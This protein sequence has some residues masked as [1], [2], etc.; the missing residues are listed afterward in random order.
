VP[1]RAGR[2]VPDDHLAGDGAAGDPRAVGRKRQA[3]R[4]RAQAPE[5]PPPRAREVEDRHL[6]VDGDRGQPAAVGGER[7][8]ERLERGVD[9]RGAGLGVDEVEQAAA[10]HRG[11]GAVG[12]E[13]GEPR[14]AR[15]RDPPQL[16]IDRQAAEQRARHQVVSR[17]EGRAQPG[18]RLELAPVR[19]RHPRGLALRVGAAPLGDGLLARERRRDRQRGDGDDG[20][21]GDPGDRE[22]PAAVAVRQRP[23]L[24]RGD[25]AARAGG[26]REAPR[27][28]HRL[29]QALVAPGLV[30][31]G[32]P[33]LPERGGLL[34]V[35][36]EAQLLAALVEP[37]GEAAPRADQGLVRELQ[38]RLGSVAAAR[39]EQPGGGE[40]LDDERRVAGEVGEQRPQRDAA[41]GALRGDQAEEQRARR[42]L[43]RRGEAG[44]HLV[45]VGGERAGDAADLLVRAPREPAAHP[46]APLPEQA[47]R[48]LQ[49]RQRRRL[50][51]DGGEDV[52]DEL[53]LVE[54]IA[55]LGERAQDDLAQHLLAG[56]AEHEHARERL[57]ELGHL[58]EPAE[59]VVARREDDAHRLPGIVGGA[60]QGAKEATPILGAGGERDQLLELVD[61]QHEPHAALARPAPQDLAEERRALAQRG[62]QR[63][64]VAGLVLV[65][66]RLG[67]GGG[68]QGPPRQARLA[69]DH[70]LGEPGERVG[71][72][73]RAEE[74]PV[75]LL[76]Q[77][78]QEPRAHERALAGARRA[79]HGKERLR[80]HPLRGVRELGVAAEEEPRLR[81]VEGE[82]AAERAHVVA[83]RGARRDELRQHRRDLRR[84]GPRRGRLVE[85]AE[86]EVEERRRRVA[87]LLP[88]HG[89]AVLGAAVKDQ[90]VQ[91]HADRPDVARRRGR[92]AAPLLRREVR[93]SPRRAAAAVVGEASGPA[94]QAEVDDARPAVA[95]DDDVLGLEVE[96]EHAVAVRLADRL[97]DR[98]G[99]AQGLAELEPA[100]D[101]PLPQGLSLEVL[102]R[103]VRAAAVLA[104]AVDGDD[105]GVAE[106][107]GRARLVE[108]ARDRAAARRCLAAHELEGHAPPEREV[109]REVDLAHPSARQEAEDL[110]SVEDVAGLD[111]HERGVLHPPG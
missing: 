31:A 103:E 62:G 42:L 49:H 104:G 82:Q 47:E 11:E 58:G 78:R 17:L 64:R 88:H 100:L 41:A 51:A 92:L 29:G 24:S 77:A 21:R 12:G 71:A 48:E 50:V 10:R 3:A 68:P 65:L 99:G 46:V 110:V 39:R 108:E 102:E 72:D 56:A 60:A 106:R 19:Q 6:S 8:R 70:H 36:G 27:Q 25:E 98:Q 45:G 57:A 9:A 1:A 111:R 105:V 67:L 18:A 5:A 4:G 44:E 74:P 87:A 61:E 23:P 85:A 66:W 91:D 2:G 96:V 34:D 63:R 80:A 81:L 89:G 33:L 55:H 84:R 20:Q 75:G 32:A 22:P 86:D 76:A 26:E 13:R 52:L 95:R 79:D 94:R 37:A 38:D 30:V 43:P 35:G 101:E 107:G 53:R 16:G 73:P 83:P 69:L 7:D 28:A 93:R 59:E 40:A 109:A 14:R 97:R 15:Q 54:R 90:L